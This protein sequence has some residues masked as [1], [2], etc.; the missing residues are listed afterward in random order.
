MEEVR[1]WQDG[2][3]G[4]AKVG[5]DVLRVGRFVDEGRMTH[6][7]GTVLIDPRIQRSKVIVM[8]LFVF[9]VKTHSI[10][11]APKESVTRMKRRLEVVAL[12]GGLESRDGGFE[13]G[14]GMLPHFLESV[15]QRLE[16]VLTM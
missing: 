1:R 5:R 4:D 13:S 16:T 3:L 6:R 2:A 15:A 7:I 9:D 10:G 14:P 8:Q 11:S 12:D